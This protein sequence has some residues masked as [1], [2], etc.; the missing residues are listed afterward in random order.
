MSD[1]YQLTFSGTGNEEMQMLSGEF[2]FNN[3]LG[4]RCH[5]S[6]LR[7]GAKGQK[8]RRHTSIMSTIPATTFILNESAS[9]FSVTR[10]P[11]E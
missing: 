10:H 2:G 8:S 5:N 7:N 4:I 11:E 3:D 9:S 1:L 6:S